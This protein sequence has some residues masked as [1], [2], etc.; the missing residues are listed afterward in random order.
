KGIV[1]KISIH[2]LALFAVAMLCHG[3]LARTRP[4]PRYL[5]GFYLLMSVGGVLGGLFNALIAPLVFN[6]LYEY[7]AALVMACMLVPPLT[8]GDTSLTDRI[9][10]LFAML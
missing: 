8:V 9:V 3:E 4:A 1:L 5:T 7:T 6:D 2:L 10:N